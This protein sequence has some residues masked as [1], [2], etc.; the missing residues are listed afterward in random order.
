MILCLLHVI[1]LCLVRIN[2]KH[3]FRVDFCVCVGGGKLALS[4]MKTTHGKLIHRKKSPSKEF[5]HYNLII[6][7]YTVKSVSF[8]FERDTFHYHK[9]IPRLIFLLDYIMNKEWI[10]WI[11]YNNT[12]L[13][14]FW[15]IW[16]D[17]FP[18][19]SFGM[20]VDKITQNGTAEKKNPIL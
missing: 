14:I 13:H 15:I 6:T 1:Y 16:M 12:I 3:F 20:K 8:N 17:F 9:M 4:W 11:N 7:N 18:V 19:S 2:L 10:K 5:T